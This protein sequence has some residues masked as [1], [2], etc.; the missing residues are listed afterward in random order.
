M[1]KTNDFP[2]SYCP[3]GWETLERLQKLFVERSQDLILAK[4]RPPSAA[5]QVMAQRHP[6][7]PCDY[8][9]PEERIAW[10][11]DYF[12][13]RLKIEDD[14]IPSAYLSE[15]DQ[16]LYGGLVGGR[17]EFQSDP[18]RGWISSMAHPILRDWSELERLTIQVDGEWFLR[19]V[20][21]LGVFVEGARGRFG[22]S[23]F[24]LIDSLNFVFE[25]VGA[26]KTYEDLLDQPEMVR[27][28][29]DFAYELNLKVQNTFFEK[30][31]LLA[32]GTCSNM[33]EWL[34]GRVISES[35]DPLHLASV[36]YFEQWGREPVE[37]IFSQFDGGCLHIHGNGRHL[38]PSVASL[39]GL[40]A[41]R[42]L[43]DGDT[44]PAF[45]VLPDL[46][47]QVGIIP[48]VVSVPYADFRAALQARTLSGGVLYVV[49]G[50]PDV[51]AANWCMEEVRDHDAARP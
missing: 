31:P 23:H 47:K 11:D 34:P 4:M 27:R 10:W 22:V 24:I 1:N 26:T 43:D 42:L 9:D 15:M 45:R 6:K 44:P 48:L 14:S 13:E 12:R 37:R 50:V 5:L 51:D 40:K 46:K 18:E 32:G 20:R 21:Q 41:I 38:L 2:L 17:V 29:V 36:D 16:G 39:R 25:L 28:A 49:D 33:V 8:P 30:V 7:G 19:Y 35:V 3:R